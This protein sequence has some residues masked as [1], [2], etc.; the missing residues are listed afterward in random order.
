MIGAISEG[1]TE[2]DNLNS[3][4]D[5]Q[6]TISCLQKLG[7]K[8]EN[9]NGR[10]VVHGRG[11]RGLAKPGGILDVGNSGT[12]IRL[13]SGILAGQEFDT[14]ITGDES[15]QKRPMARIVQPL[16]KMGVQV[17]AVDN[18]FAPLSIRSGNLSAINYKMPMA[19]AQVKSCVL[20]AGLYP[21][22]VTQVLEP[23]ESRDHTERMLSF[24]EGKIKKN[25]LRVSVQGPASLKGKKILIPCDLSSAAFF[26]AAA[27]LVKGSEIMIENVGINPTRTGFLDLL[28]DMGAELEIGKNK[29]ENNEPVTDICVKSSALKGVTIS[30]KIIPKLIDEI[31]I[32][33]ILATQA[34]GVTKISDAQELRNKESDR[35]Q[36]VAVNLKR[37]GAQV[38]ENT[39][40]LTIKGPVQLK[41]A[42][43]DSFSDHRIAMAFAIAGLIADQESVINDAECVDVSCPGFYEDLTRLSGA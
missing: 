17:G 20:F 41:A 16:R 29:E 11:L 39:D 18:K 8:I 23:A 32:L 2:I 24:F 25:G 3:G 34:E 7:V 36:T 13:L 21:E 27:V 26:I 6:S 33:A 42:E 37:M 30:G 40:G 12:T 31:P 1:L 9:E 4:Q 5:V 38:E 35:L 10:T 43:L 28:R 22:G 14:T 19:S 15:I